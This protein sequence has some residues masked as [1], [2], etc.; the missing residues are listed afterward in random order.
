MAE[1]QNQKKTSTLIIGYLVIAA[2]LVGLVYF[3]FNFQNILTKYVTFI[4]WPARW[5]KD[6]VSNV[7]ELPDG[8]FKNQE[9]YIYI[10]EFMKTD[11]DPFESV[12]EIPNDKLL[13]FGINTAF[14]SENAINYDYNYVK[15][16]TIIPSSDIQ[17]FIHE[18]FGRTASNR[19]TSQF[20]YNVKKN[21]YTV[22]GSALDMPYNYAVTDV[23]KIDSTTVELTINFTDPD[24]DNIIK[25]MKL[26]L[27]GADGAY[28]FVKFQN[29]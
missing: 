7:S 9:L 20:T 26:T 19:S 12:S 15:N 25:S 1:D 28:K 3:A 10:M 17:S 18:F 13:L 14:V 29:V 23:L 21:E 16:E 22:P 6:Y 2:L 8:D 5:Y 27:E 4:D 24:N 11:F